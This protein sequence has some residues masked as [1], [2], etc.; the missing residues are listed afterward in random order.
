M[1]RVGG[2]VTRAGTC[3]VI[4]L[5]LSITPIF[6]ESETDSVSLFTSFSIPALKV[7]FPVQA[8]ALLPGFTGADEV[9]L[10]ELLWS[11]LAA[12]PRSFITFT[13]KTNKENEQKCPNLFIL[14]PVMHCETRT[15]A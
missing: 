7:R 2:G 3:Q 8:A 13:L 5:N 10:D 12:A 14:I 15:G 11:L 9:L 6:P 1:K 4:R